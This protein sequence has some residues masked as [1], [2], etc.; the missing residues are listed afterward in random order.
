VYGLLLR[1]QVYSKVTVNPV[2]SSQGVQEASSTVDV[3]VLD[4]PAAWGPRTQQQKK[5]GAGPAAT[6]SVIAPVSLG[7]YEF[8][9][10]GT[11]AT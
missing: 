8:D 9:W 1:V 11:A 2:S 5:A 10:G 6:G 3:T 4:W 7:W